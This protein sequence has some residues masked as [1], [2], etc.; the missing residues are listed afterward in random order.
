MTGRTHDLAAVT[1]LNFIVA[2]QHVP[3][4]TLATGVA[5]YVACGIGGLMPDIDQST[6]HLYR[7]LPAGT[8]I[9]KLLSPFFGG[10]RAISH[11][12]LGVFLFGFLVKFILTR[13]H[14]VLLV[15]M[16]A[17]WWAFM[18]GFVSHLV[19][20]TIS[21]DGVPYLF[22]VPWRFGFPPLRALRL[23]TGGI[24]EKSFIFPGLLFI[25]SILIYIYYDTYLTILRSMLQVSRQ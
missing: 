1:A 18:I 7:R 17:V 16:D 13:L 19:M 9:G 10:H 25:N 4:A 22:P 14:D 15:D 12:I 21:R 23:K 20:D 3:A 6:A 24:V 8:V 2:T 11:S 5:A